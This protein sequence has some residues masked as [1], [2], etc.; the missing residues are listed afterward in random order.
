MTPLQL[1]VHSQ[2]PMLKL[3]HKKKHGRN[4]VG[5]LVDGVWVNARYHPL[6]AHLR[7]LGCIAREWI[8]RERIGRTG[9][10]QWPLWWG[11]AEEG[12]GGLCLTDVATDFLANRIQVPWGIWYDNENNILGAMADTVTVHEAIER[13][14][15]FSATKLQYESLV[16]QMDLLKTDNTD[17]TDNDLHDAIRLEALQFLNIKKPRVF[18]K[19]SAT[20]KPV[21]PSIGKKHKKGLVLESELKDGRKYVLL[22]DVQ[23]RVRAIS[24]GQAIPWLMKQVGA[25]YCR[26]EKGYGPSGSGTMRSRYH[27]LEPWGFMTKRGR[28][29]APTQRGIDFVEERSVESHAV[30]CKVLANGKTG[31]VLGFCPEKLDVRTMLA[32][33]NAVRVN[34]HKKSPLEYDQL[35]AMFLAPYRPVGD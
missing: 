21:V 20:K 25:W 12:P 35:V 11:F 32:R 19:I 26:G 31:K 5:V 17:N 8:T 22:N 30:W 3:V 14:N 4:H 13:F 33:G 29:Y 18:G 6:S 7:R 2:L 9:N 24:F 10:P 28:L 16:D 34:I 23:V 15:Q 1:P 27:A